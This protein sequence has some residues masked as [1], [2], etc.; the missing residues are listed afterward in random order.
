M[1]TGVRDLFH[2]LSLPSV[3][4]DSQRLPV[5][6]ICLLTGLETRKALGVESV[7]PGR[8]TDLEKKREDQ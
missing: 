1:L 4:A 7:V 5:R 6:Q 3:H 8:W 2:T